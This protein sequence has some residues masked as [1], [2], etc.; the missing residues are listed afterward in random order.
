M[1]IPYFGDISK[2]KQSEWVVCDGNN[3]SPKLTGRFITGTAF[4]GTT[5]VPHLLMKKVNPDFISTFHLN[6]PSTDRI[7]DPMN[8]NPNH[9]PIHR[10]PSFDFLFVIKI[11]MKR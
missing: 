7:T 6:D 5:P 8:P 10:V 11:K 2:V 3:G 9:N 4:D 1:I